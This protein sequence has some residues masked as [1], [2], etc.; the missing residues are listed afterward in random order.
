MKAVSLVGDREFDDLQDLKACGGWSRWAR[1][2]SPDGWRQDTAHAYV[3]P[4]L[5]DNCHSNL[6]VLVETQVQRVIFDQNHHATGVEITPNPEF[7]ITTPLSQPAPTGFIRAKKQVMVSCGA[8]GSPVLL[9][10]SGIGG[11]QLLNKIGVPV[12]SDLPGVGENLQDHHLVLYPYKTSLQ[13]EETIDDV[14][15]G[16]VSP[17]IA[18][19]KDYRHRAWNAGDISSKLRPSNQEVDAIGG[20]FKEFWDRDYKSQIEKPL[21]LCAIHN[22]FFGDHSLVPRG[23]YM[24]VATYS[25]YPYSRGSIHASGKT[26]NLEPDLEPGFLRHEFDINMLVWAYK[27]TREIMRRTNYY[28]GELPINHPEFPLGSN[29][30]LI[31]LEEPYGG[32]SVHSL[33]NIE[34][35]KQDDDAIVRHIKKHVSTTWHSLGTCA[36]KSVENGG[37]VDKTLNVH[38]VTGLKVAGNYGISFGKT[39]MY[40][41]LIITL[42]IFL[43]FPKTSV[44]TLVTR[45]LLLAKR[46]RISSAQSWMHLL[47]IR[48]STLES[49][50]CEAFCL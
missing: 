47:E 14:L 21:I 28:R 25:A 27:K 11:A 9:E 44:Q 31:T 32:Q 35:T 10:R 15:S 48:Q 20:T 41:T 5:Q 2:V 39:H 40:L 17:E 46:Q 7:Q 16:R 3:H 37:V 1:F 33:K 43:L 4:L 29:A 8:L 6:H 22:A 12:V 38:G 45:Q 13:P 36:M 50:S 18:I 24:T 34:Y 30:G 49:I 26:A 19:Q 23:Q 42:Q